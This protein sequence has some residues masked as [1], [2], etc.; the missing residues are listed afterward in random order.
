MAGS[1]GLPHH[2]LRFA[3]LHTIHANIGNL[4]GKQK[5]LAETK[6]KRLEVETSA[7]ELATMLDADLTRRAAELEDALSTTDMDATR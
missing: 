4:C 2:G 7:Q 5:E 1:G 6:A 3:P